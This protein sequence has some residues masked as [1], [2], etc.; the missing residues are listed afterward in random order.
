[1]YDVHYHMVKIFQFPTSNYLTRVLRRISKFMSIKVNSLEFAYFNKIQ[2][3][4]HPERQNLTNSRFALLETRE[5]FCGDISNVYSVLTIPTP[6]Q[7]SLSN[8]N[9]ESKYHRKIVVVFLKARILNLQVF[10]FQSV[11][12]LILLGILP[13]YIYIIFYHCKF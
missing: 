5:Q 3:K 2:E 6:F 10:V 4:T 1:M 13:L 11:F 9:E 8:Q 7:N 12:F